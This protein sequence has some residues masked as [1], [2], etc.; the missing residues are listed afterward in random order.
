M[1]PSIINDE[2]Q[3]KIEIKRYF[4]KNLLFSNKYQKHNENI[5]KR[6]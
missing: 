1:Y 4:N 3:I 5:P 2:K 6:K